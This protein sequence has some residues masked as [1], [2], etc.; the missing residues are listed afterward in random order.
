MSHFLMKFP[1][2]S[3]PSASC[4]EWMHREQEA[5]VEHWWNRCCLRSY[6][7]AIKNKGFLS[8][9]VI[10]RRHR[11]LCCMRFDLILWWWEAMGRRF[12]PSW[13]EHRPGDPAESWA[14]SSWRVKRVRYLATCKKDGDADQL[15][16]SLCRVSHHI[17]QRLPRWAPQEGCIT[18]RNDS[19]SRSCRCFASSSHCPRRIS[20]CTPWVIQSGAH[21]HRVRT[22]QPSCKFMNRKQS[23]PSYQMWSLLLLHEHIINPDAGLSR[24]GTPLPPD[25]SLHD[26]LQQSNKHGTS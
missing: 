3:A 5:S 23:S 18:Y 15:T 26:H 11:G 14:R 25:N 22:D 16:V 6:P 4:C 19:C 9:Q 10:N 24:A 1:A 17:R 20:W 2:E 21:C 13:L 8:N 12:H 7:A